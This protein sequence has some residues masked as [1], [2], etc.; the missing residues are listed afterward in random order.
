MGTS[1]QK[2]A[3]ETIKNIKVSPED[4]PRKLA[5][6]SEVLSDLLAFNQDMILTT[7]SEHWDVTV[8]LIMDIYI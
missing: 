8:Q 4:M 2:M 3:T 7:K 6:K 5:V 1:D